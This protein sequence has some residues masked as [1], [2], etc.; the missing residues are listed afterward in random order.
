M[1]MDVMTDILMR[2]SQAVWTGLSV[3]IR[4][5]LQYFNQAWA[6]ATER[7]QAEQRRLVIGFTQI[8][9]TLAIASFIVSYL[10]QKHSNDA[11]DAGNKA[12]ILNNEMTWASL[13]Y[14]NVRHSRRDRVHAPQLNEN[15]ILITALS[16]GVT[17]M[18][19]ECSNPMPICQGG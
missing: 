14:A 8:V 5:C 1:V 16:N 2:S 7:R 11:A 6:W 12:A 15:R 4:T 9:A 18:S 3:S 17:R 10:Q 19:I 13:C